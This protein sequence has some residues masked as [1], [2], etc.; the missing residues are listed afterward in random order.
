MPDV[1]LDKEVL[2]AVKKHLPSV[3]AGALMEELERLRGVE[4]DHKKVCEDRDQYKNWWSNDRN[5]LHEMAGKVKEVDDRQAGLNKIEQE[6]RDREQKCLLS[7]LENKLTVR[8]QEQ[9]FKLVETVFKG[10]QYKRTIDGYVPVA[11]EGQAANQYSSYGTAG[12][13][14]TGQVNVTETIQNV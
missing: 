10:P 2:E 5:K 7:E 13:V 1:K 8:H 11:V 12:S 3:T 6:L 4:A 9:I 14:Q